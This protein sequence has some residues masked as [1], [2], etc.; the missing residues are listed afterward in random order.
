MRYYWSPERGC[1]ALLTIDAQCDFAWPNAPAKVCGTMAAVP[2]MRRLVDSFRERNQPIV[3]VVRIY[4]CDGSNVEL[5]HR[6]AIEEGQRIVMPGSSG[7]ELVE[8]L[9][10]DKTQR[11]EPEVL[12]AG[13][14]Q[15]L[16]PNEHVM[17]KPRWSAFYQTTLEEHLRALGVTTL[18]VCGCDFPRGPRATI[19]A[20]SN[21]DFRIVL[22]TAA[23]R[24]R[25][26]R[27]RGAG[28]LSRRRHRRNQQ[29][30][31]P[32]RPGRRQDRAP[33]R[34]HARRAALR[35]DGA[36]AAGPPPRQGHQRRAGAGPPCCR[37][38]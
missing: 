36:A 7:A 28:P 38:R 34:R 30:A 14:F 1:A 2:A 35:R 23:G 8:A 27:P 21:R 10:R 18:V 25:G 19:Y 15:R 37:R 20:A 31:G 11:L 12:L 22:V 33:S 3:H 4:R 29:A 26:G 24:A 16:G 32:R 6:A 9:K 17:Y 5:C 13:Q